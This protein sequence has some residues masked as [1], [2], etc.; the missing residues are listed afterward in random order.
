MR[1]WKLQTEEFMVKVY[2][3][4]EKQKITKSLDYQMDEKGNILQKSGAV[5]PKAC[6][7]CGDVFRTDSVEDEIRQE[8]NSYKCKDCE[9]KSISADEALKHTINEKK[10]ELEIVEDSKV[11]G[12]RTTLEGVI[13]IVSKTKDDVFVLC[14]GC[15]DSN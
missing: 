11:V 13:P 15:H 7:N 9:F 12:V 3:K 8:I 2:G 14:R 5:I 10:H 1:D 4:K 6:Q